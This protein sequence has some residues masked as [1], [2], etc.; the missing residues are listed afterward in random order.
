M[1]DTHTREQEVKEAEKGM[2]GE[3]VAPRLSVLE[4]VEDKCD[5]NY[6]RRL[7]LSHP[8]F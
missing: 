6:C 4:D 7:T 8:P 1:H 5:S 3:D 2:E